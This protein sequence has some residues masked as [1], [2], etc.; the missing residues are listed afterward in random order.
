MTSRGFL[1]V[2]GVITLVAVASYLPIGTGMFNSKSKL[3][4]TVPELSAEAQQ[5]YALF[6][7]AC[8]TCHGTKADGTDNGPALIIRT[9]HPGRHADIAFYR[10]VKLGVR[11]HHFHFGGMPP[12]DGISEAEIANIVMFIRETQKANGVF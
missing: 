4:V 5:G 2:L 8:A 6:R 1:I 10:A 9:Y 11:Q 12:I 3:D 7:N